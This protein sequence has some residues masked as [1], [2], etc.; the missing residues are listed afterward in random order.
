MSTVAPAAARPAASVPLRRGAADELGVE[1]V[2]ADIAALPVWTQWPP[3]RQ[4]ATL[5]TA[6]RVL[7]GLTAHPGTGWQQR[8]TSAGVEHST[9]WDAVVHQ[10]AG[11]EAHA[12]PPSRLAVKQG[13]MGL[14]L[15]QVIL[16]GYGFL[17]DLHPASHWYREART[18]LAPAT[19]AHLADRAT[20][21]GITEHLRDQALLVVVKMVLHTGLDPARLGVAEFDEFLTASRLRGRSAPGGTVAAWDLLRGGGIPAELSYREHHRAGPQSTAELVDGHGLRCRPVRDVLVR[22]LDE[23]RPALDFKSFR[24]MVG[25]LVGAFWA[26]IEAHH[27]EVESLQLPDEVAAAWKQRLRYTRRAGVPSR[28]RRDYLQH[29]M[30]VRAFYLDIAEWALQDPTW[31]EHAVVCP[32]RRT[33]LAGVAKQR[34]RT[35]AAVHQRIRERLPRLPVLVDTAHR[36]YQDRAQLL[37]A[38]QAVAVG[39]EFTHDGR[40]YRRTCRQR[41]GQEDNRPASARAEN[42]ADG[43]IHDLFAEED[44]AFWS[45]AIIETLRHTGIRLEELLELTHLAVIQHRLDDTGEVVPLLQILPSK[46]DQERLLLVSPELAAVLATIIN[47]LRGINEGVVPVVRRWDRHERRFSLALPHLFQRRR[48]HRNSVIGVGGVQNLLKRTLDRAGLRDAAGDPL[49]FTPH[50]F[51]R[52]FATEAVTGGL[53]VHITAALLGHKRI[54]SSESY[55]AVFQ[56]ELIRTY[57]SHLVER[58]ELRPAAEYREPTDDEWREFQQHFSLRKLELGTCARPYGSPC[59]HEHACIRCPMLRVDPRQRDRLA[60]IT[61]SLRERISEAQL[62]GW[63]GEIE[64]LRISLQAAE[65]KLVT[66]DR[67]TRSTPT[68][69]GLPHVN[70]RK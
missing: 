10:L 62:N 15:A 54:T 6:R 21:L 2:A 31:A 44:D 60:E 1:E 50:D 53:P 41:P 51:R 29:L 17:A 46:T 5:R 7:V 32:I 68:S 42:L 19:F 22:Y 40:R 23:R 37:A 33:E 43:Q 56:D 70:S 34:H 61:A 24:N 8:W 20:E 4:R 52:I 11:T 27:P 47:R 25:H 18:V 12:G 63:H 58:R 26:D 14:M 69:L 38:T 67:R 59:Q 64:G 66:L 9:P 3:S 30:M 45:W 36:H 49:H 65:S 28:P 13:L 39:E 35:I 48:G 16:P 57:R 55:V